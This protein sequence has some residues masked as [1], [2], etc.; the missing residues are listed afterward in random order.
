MRPQEPHWGTLRIADD[1]GMQ[2]PAST[3]HAALDLPWQWWRPGNPSDPVS[4]TRC[5]GSC[6]AV[7]RARREVRCSAR[8]EGRYRGGSDAHNAVHW[9]GAHDVGGGGALRCVRRGGE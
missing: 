2:P 4:L 5:V 8:A 1:K 7:P 9:V 6:N 3:Q